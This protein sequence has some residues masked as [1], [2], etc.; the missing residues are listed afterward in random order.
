MKT[1]EA[2]YLYD[3]ILQ[4]FHK[5]VAPAYSEE[6]IK[7][8]LRMLSPEFLKI[9][10]PEQFTIV[11]EQNDQIYGTLSIINKNHIALLFVKSEMQGEGI[12]KSLIQFA[13]HKCLENN[14]DVKSITV[15]SSPNSLTFYQNFGFIIPEEEKNEKGMRIIPMEKKIFKYS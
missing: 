11:A 13:T 4:V 3:I 14:P 1:E 9:V 8:F 2:N 7:T 10:T 12:G 5:H 6:G 15:S